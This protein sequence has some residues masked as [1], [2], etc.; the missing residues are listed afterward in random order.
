MRAKELA[1]FQWFKTA[2][3]WRIFERTQDPL[4]NDLIIAKPLQPTPHQQGLILLGPEEF[5]IP[6]REKSLRLS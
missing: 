6:Y 4:Q 5:V 1:P 2:G 3:D